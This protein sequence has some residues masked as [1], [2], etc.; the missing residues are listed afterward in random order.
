MGRYEE[1][2]SGDGDG[3]EI[4]WRENIRSAARFRVRK[5]WLHQRLS[6]CHGS[7]SL[8]QQPVSEMTAKMNGQSKRKIADGVL[9]DHKGCSFA[10]GRDARLED[11]GQ[12]C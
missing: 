4:Q 12:F 11:F 1:R 9:D 2:G 7:E 3:G 6:T 8:N 5:N 10:N